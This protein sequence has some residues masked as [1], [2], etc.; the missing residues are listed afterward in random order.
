MNRIL[1]EKA[2]LGQEVPA[3]VAREIGIAALGRF[4]RVLVNSARKHFKRAAIERELSRLD[5]RMLE[6]LGL[7]WGDISHVAETAV[8]VPGEGNLF[9]EFSRMLVNLLVRP[10]VLWNRRREVYDTL[11]A[12]D[13]RML[14]DIGLA[15]YDIADYVRR[16]GREILEPLPEPFAAMEQDVTAP[17]R[18][19][20]R[21][22]L[23]AKQLSSLTDRQLMDIGVVRGDIA[24]LA[25]DV[26]RKAL[27]AANL[28]SQ[29]HAQK[30]A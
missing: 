19:W 18:M 13:D 5:T 11:M 25:H 12:M 28:N 2:T 9:A 27:V 7:R 15:R 30:A 1:N 3:T 26:A 10:V 22:R 17:I 23:T 14:S 4:G 29:S 8:A 16:L 20:N 6:D 24:E 21:A